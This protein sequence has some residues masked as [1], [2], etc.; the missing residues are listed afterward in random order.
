MAEAARARGLKTLTCD[1]RIVAPLCDHQGLIVRATPEQ[2]QVRAA[3]R[4]ITG[5]QT[6]RATITTHRHQ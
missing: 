2:G 5:R 6:A 3:V 4:D 1:Y